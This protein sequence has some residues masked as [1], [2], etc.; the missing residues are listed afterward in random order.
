MRTLK[1]YTEYVNPS[2][3]EVECSDGLRLTWE[4]RNFP[5]GSRSKKYQML[6]FLLN[7]YDDT[8]AKNQVDRM[9]SLA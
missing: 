7:N 2:K 4:S 8:R 1:D 9:L 5:G 6:L 3:I